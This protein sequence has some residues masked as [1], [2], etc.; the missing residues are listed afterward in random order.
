ME[1]IP[2]Q[3]KF[4]GLRV[5]LYGPESTGK[6]TLSR[7]LATHYKTSFVEEFARDYLQKKYDK[8]GEVCS[9]DDLIPIAM[10]QRELENKAVSTAIDLLF[11]DTDPL[12][13]L[14]YS[15]IYFNRAPQELVETV[16][17]SYYDLYLLLDVDLPWIPDDLRDRPHDRKSIFSTFKSNLLIYNKNF[18]IISGMNEDRFKA[19]V[20][21]IENYRQQ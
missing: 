16:E 5:V 9:F 18:E 20:T 7:K 8:S 4:N 21:A 17:K 3:K 12:E 15:E 11:C 6:T 1:K 14:T 10:G 2:Q 13:T 19:A